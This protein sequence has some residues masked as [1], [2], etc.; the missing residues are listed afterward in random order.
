M[1][2]SS[3]INIKQNVRLH[4]HDRSMHPEQLQ[5]DEIKNLPTIGHYL[6]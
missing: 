2:D 5:L 1:P 4:G 6:L 3:T